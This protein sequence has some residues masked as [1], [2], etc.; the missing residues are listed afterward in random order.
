MND[1]AFDL[2]EDQEFLPTDNGGGRGTAD[3]GRY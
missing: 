2:V 1:L 3:E